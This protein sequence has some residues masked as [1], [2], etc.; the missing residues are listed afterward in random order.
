M[1]MRTHVEPSV[2]RNSGRGAKPAG[3]SDGDQARAVTTIGR[4]LALVRDRRTI[5]LLRAAFQGIHRFD[6][7]C[8]DLGI[9][10]PLLTVRLRRL[11]DAGVM[12]KELYQRHP[13]RYGYRL[14]PAGVALSPAV[15][16]LVRWGDEHMSGGSPSTILVHAPCG[17]ELEQGSWCQECLTT[18]GPGAIRGL[19]PSRPT[20]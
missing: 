16:A 1:V 5:L 19:A 7:F 17:T 9:G 12:T 20:D 15:V 6:H 8:A 14:T 11:V 10:R 2:S 3:A 13:L 18:F 4:T